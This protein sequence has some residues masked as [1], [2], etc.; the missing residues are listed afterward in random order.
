MFIM[1]RQIQNAINDSAWFK[2]LDIELQTSVILAAK[3]R[4]LSHGAAAY[5]QGDASDGLYVVIDG[6]VRLTSYSKQGAGFLLLLAGPGDWFG[7]VSTLDG[8]PRQQDAVSDGDSL[9]MHLPIEAL[10]RIAETTPR[11]WRMVGRLASQHQRAALKYIS[12]LVTMPAHAR[13]LMF[14]HVLND[15]KFGLPLSVT[16]DEIAANVGLS[17]QTVNAVLQRLQAQGL[18]QLGYRSIR[19]VG[20][21]SKASTDFV[22]ARSPAAP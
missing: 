20:D 11:L 3:R 6:H 12:M 19:I 10:E 5:R 8:D 15:R 2:S 21:L 13:V 4:P 9:V 22:P 18:I 7:E 17:R 14:L 16:H 1:D